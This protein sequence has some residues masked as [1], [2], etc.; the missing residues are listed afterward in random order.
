MTTELAVQCRDHLHAGP[1]TWDASLTGIEQLALGTRDNVT[2]LD[3]TDAIEG[4]EKTK[5]NF[6]KLNIFKFSKNQQR[7]RAGHYA[8]ART[9]ESDTRNILMSSGE[10]IL[11]EARHVRGQDV[12]MVHIPACI[13]DFDD[14]FDA[15]DAFAK[16]GKTVKERE[17]FVS[18]LEARTREFQGCALLAF[19]HRL[20]NDNDADR[21]LARYMGEFVSYAPLLQSRRIF[22]RLRRRI[23]AC[24]AGTTLAR[25]YR[26]LP[27]T[28]Q[29]VFQDFRKC[30]NDAL[31][32]LIANESKASIS[33]VPHLSD[34]RL[35]ADFRKQLGA[36]TFLKVGRY[37]NRAR[38]LTQYDIETAAGFIK[39]HKPD[40]FQAMIPTRRVKIWYSDKPTRSRLVVLLRKW[41]IFSAGRQADTAARQTKIS[42]YPT[43]IPYYRISLKALGLRLKKN[44][45]RSTYSFITH[46]S[47][48]PSLPLLGRTQRYYAGQ[49][50]I[51]KLARR[52]Q[53]AFCK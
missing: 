49:A 13:S 29:E 14:I 50:L 20:V 1:T 25:H 11:I 30:M 51:G 6:V 36:A 16:V 28:K 37:A 32:L 53:N 12:R 3:E 2:L 33:A 47:V 34:H 39:F 42:P 24:A 19:L 10:D 9:V 52:G 8:R 21:T 17:Q 26:I 41:K 48:R 35:V 22:A 4:N 18:E 40:R 23:A 15:D 38:P 27:F 7:L 46:A 45:F 44:F 43:K 31:D 5:A